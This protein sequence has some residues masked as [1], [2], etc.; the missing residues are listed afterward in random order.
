[1]SSSPAACNYP[2]LSSHYPRLLTDRTMTA[3]RVVNH[4]GIQ[5]CTRWE[6]RSESQTFSN[7]QFPYAT[8]QPPNQS[9]SPTNTQLRYILHLN[10]GRRPEFFGRTKRTCVCVTLSGCK[11]ERPFQ[12][13]PPPPPASLHC[14]PHTLATLAACLIGQTRQFGNSSLWF[15][16][17]PTTTSCFHCFN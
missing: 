5:T 1:M 7:M 15:F 8:L 17:I 16:L 10:R 9:P 4:L 3:S 13:S 6:S 14:I 12:A 11:V 2:S